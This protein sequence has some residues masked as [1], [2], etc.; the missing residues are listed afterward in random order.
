MPS[1]RGGVRRAPA[2]WVRVCRFPRFFEEWRSHRM[3]HACPSDENNARARVCRPVRPMRAP[4]LVA[5]ARACHTAA[6]LS[7][8][9]PDLLSRRLVRP[10]PPAASQ[11]LFDGER[12]GANDGGDFVEPPAAKGGDGA[13]AARERCDS[14]ESFTDEGDDGAGDGIAAPELG[15]R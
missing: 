13:A 14:D 11:R 9:A 8:L 1:A 10:R 2:G 6:A 5:T 4:S 15:G 12:E 3:A 7:P